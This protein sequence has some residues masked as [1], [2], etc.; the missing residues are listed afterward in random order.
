MD[1]TQ[2]QQTQTPQPA[3]QRP[4]LERPRQDRAIAGVASGLARHFGIDVAWVRIGFVVAALFGGSG[5]LL[6]IVGWLAIPEE[7]ETESIAVVK[8]GGFERAGS[9]IGIGLIVLAGLIILGNTT[10]IER[11]L[12]FAAALIVVGV[13]LYRGDFGSVRDRSA[14]AGMPPT[15]PVPASASPVAAESPIPAEEAQIAAP[16]DETFP[17]PEPPPPPLR[18]SPPPPPNV[19]FQPR[20]SRERSPLGRFG[21]AT[22]LIVVGI[23][24]VGQS[25]DWW[26]P[27][28]RHYAAAI[29]VVLGATLVVSSVFGRARG[30]IVLGLILAPF[31]IAMALLKVPFEGGFG[32]PHHVPASIGELAGEYRLMAGEMVLDL[33]DL[34][35]D[36]GE[37]ATVEAS[38]V[39][40]RL[41]V[42][43]PM[44]LGVEVDAAVDAGEMLL[45]GARGGATRSGGSDNVGIERTIEYGG[46]GLVILDA[47]V[48]FGELDVHQTAEVMP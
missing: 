38:V 43:V 5:I 22:A 35:F 46:D 24:G 21:F 36:E 44:N 14:E 34:E 30:L 42:I 23:M 3:L 8:T 37:V 1:S 10:F 33:T 29:L 41:E 18:E 16:I 9:W 17:V 12:L 20:L 28:L 47:H 45:D 48:G 13:L 19:A 11:D 32:N 40:G 4:R 26:D 6:Y 7:G 39:F 15:P 31:L 25:A 27:N 2:E